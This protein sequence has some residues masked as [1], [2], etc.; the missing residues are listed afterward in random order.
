VGF[1]PEPRVVATQEHDRAFLT[2]MAAANAFATPARRAAASWIAAG[3]GTLSP[4]PAG[5][6]LGGDGQWT[7]PGWS[8][9]LRRDLDEKSKAGV[10]LAAPG[11]AGIAFAVWDGGS[12]DRAG[13]KSFSVWQ[14]LVLER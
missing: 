2:A 7:N 11:R 13:S 12:G 14:D 9:V 5:A 10:A 6:S 4:S 3:P 8:V 1:R